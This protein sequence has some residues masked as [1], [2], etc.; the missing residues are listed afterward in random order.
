MNK[1][2]YGFILGMVF[3]MFPFQAVGQQIRLNLDPDKL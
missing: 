1:H 3:F 2:M